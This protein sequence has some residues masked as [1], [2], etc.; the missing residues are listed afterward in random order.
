MRSQSLS[1][2]IYFLREPSIMYIEAKTL[3]KGDFFISLDLNNLL[4]SLKTN[5]IRH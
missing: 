3:L 1:F 2:I 5:L 4:K